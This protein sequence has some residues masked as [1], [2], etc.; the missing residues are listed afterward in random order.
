MQSAVWISSSSSCQGDA[1]PC[2]YIVSKPVCLQ[3]GTRKKRQ[4]S[5]IVCH[6][7]HVFQVA[8]CNTGSPQCEYAAGEQWSL[9][10][11]A[12]WGPGILTS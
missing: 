4:Q 7:C 9:T 12:V 3:A 11:M 5:W 1:R 8:P 10:H 2:I 6:Q